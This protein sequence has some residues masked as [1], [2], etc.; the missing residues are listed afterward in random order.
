MAKAVGDVGNQVQVFAFGAA[1][2]LIDGLDDDLDDV[3][4]L[5]FVEAAD[6]VSFSNFAVVENHVNR[7]GVV[8]D[9]EPVANVFALAVNRERLLV[10]DVVDEQRNELFGELVRAIVVGAVRDDRRHAV[11]VVERAHEMVGASL[12]SRIRGVRRVL[13][14]LVEEIVTVS[15]MVFRTGRRSR[16]RRRDALRVVH[17]ESAVNFIRRNV[18]EALALVLFREAFPVELGSLQKA[19]RTHDVRTS[20]SKR[21][22]DGTVHV[23]FC[24]KMDDAIDLFI[25]HELVERVEVADVHLDELVVRLIFDIL[26]VCE[27]ACVCKLVEIDNLVFRILVHEQAHDMATDKACSACNNNRSFHAFLQFTWEI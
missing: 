25:L 14:R 23:A 11:G 9:K 18:I 27:I 26:E 12:R 17:L 6:V 3:D 22:L 5:P 24:S 13:R 4:V 19:E 20:K 8:F 10:A 15:Q 21:V 2:Q 7:T 1:E 16:E